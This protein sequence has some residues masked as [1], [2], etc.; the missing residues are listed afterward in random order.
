VRHCGV[1]AFYILRVFIVSAPPW[2]LAESARILGVVDRAI[3]LGGKYLGI[4]GGLD[5]VEHLIARGYILKVNV[6][7]GPVHL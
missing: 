6:L 3:L 5:P 7:L 2:G 4:Y 1:E